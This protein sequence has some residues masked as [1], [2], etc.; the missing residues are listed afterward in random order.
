[1][2]GRKISS[3]IFACLLDKN[4]QALDKFYSRDAVVAT[5]F[6]SLDLNCQTIILKTL[7]INQKNLFLEA[8]R[9]KKAM[10]MLRSLKLVDLVEDKYAL[11]SVFKSALS[12]V[13]SQ[14]L[15]P[16]FE[17]SERNVAEDANDERWTQIYAYILK[18]V[19]NQTPKHLTREAIEVLDTEG[20]VIN[21]DDFNEGTSKQQK[22]FGFGFLVQ[23]LTSQINFFMLYL[24]QY[25]FRHNFRTK[26]EKFDE[27]ELIELFCALGILHPNYW[28]RSSSRLPQALQHTIF[29]T[30]ASI[31]LLAY[32]DKQNIIKASK[33]LSKFLDP[34]KPEVE[35]YKT[36]IIVENDFRLYAY[37][38]MDFLKYFLS[39]LTR[40][41]HGHPD[42]VP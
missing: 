8:K 25:L 16:L 13:M 35:H 19:S 36:N 6:R 32:N 1:M 31:G 12:R 24:T 4:P 17:Q 21:M 40:P 38:S 28:Y 22:S 20:L 29:S 27:A 26:G 33:L 5:L 34:S 7:S 18:N 2:E 14:G 39:K 30:L 42:S 11:N 10:D 3:T 9:L 41:V 37:S 15:R 23:P